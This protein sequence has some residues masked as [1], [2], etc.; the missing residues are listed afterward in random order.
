MNVTEEHMR[1]LADVTTD[2]T[3][4]TGGRIRCIGA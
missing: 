3:S 4:S 1:Q 2:N